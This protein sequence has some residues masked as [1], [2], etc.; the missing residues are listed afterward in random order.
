MLK[1]KNLS[2]TKKITLLYLT[3]FLPLIFFRFPDIR[4]EI[5][6]LIITKESLNN[7][8]FILNYLNSLYPDKPPL[9]FWFLKIL[10]N[11]FPKYFFKLG[12]LFGSIIPSYLVS[13]MCYKF[14]IKFK[15]IHKN[16]ENLAFPIALSLIASPLYIG[17]TSVLRM[18]MLMYF[19]IFF[20][21]Y[22]FFN[23]YFNFINLNFK[24]LFLM[25]FFIFL[26]LFTKGIVGLIGPISII[27][28]FLFLNKDLKYLKKVHF[29]KGFLFVVFGIS[30]WFFGLYNSPKG[31]EYIKLLIG[32]ET[33]NRI[34]NSKTHIRPIYYYMKNF[35]ILFV[36]YGIS[37]LIAL[38]YYIKKIKN[39]V[40]WNELEKIFFSI[41][42]PLFILLSFASGKLSIYLLPTILGFL[43]LTILYLDKFKN[44]FL[45][46]VLLNIS[47]L[48]LIIPFFLNKKFNKEN[49]LEKIL[50]ISNYTMLFVV[51]LVSINSNYYSNN[52]T[53]KLF[54]EKINKLPSSSIYLYR[55]D[56]FKNTKYMLNKKIIP[57]DNKTN[58]NLREE[59]FIITKANKNEEIVKDFN[60]LK[61]VLK[62]KN[63]ILYKF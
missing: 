37:I 35:P 40:N 33:I 18:D 24:N 8:L 16:I 2:P 9:Y 11:Y 32:Q 58:F 47:M 12:I 23:F 50:N 31:L 38:F 25:Y 34:T 21:T 22:I 30:V 57:I 20:S 48:T 63:Y 1:I 52:Y 49:R 44:R 17:G 29:L 46:K 39:F 14:L 36:P 15:N 5:K 26:G 56:D 10:D 41:S 61:L 62:N 6:Y 59:N 3:I 55:F 43:G 28:S 45:V 7:N 13:I 60:N 27:F 54:L 19:F 51:F 42:L 53:L 4:N